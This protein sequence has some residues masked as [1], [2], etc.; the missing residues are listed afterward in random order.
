MDTVSVLDKTKFLR[1]RKNIVFY[2]Y[3]T[4]LLVDYKG[5]TI[6]VLNPLDSKIIKEINGRKNIENIYQCLKKTEKIDQKIYEQS[7]YKMLETGI[8]LLRDTCK[9]EKAI[10]Y[11]EVGKFY[12][13]SILIEL[14]NKCNFSCSFCYKNA[15]NK[16]VFI[17]DKN[18]EYVYDIIKEKVPS[19][20]LTGGEPTLHPHIEKYIMKFADVAK[21]NINTN[22]SRLFELNPEIV[23]LLNHVQISLYGTNNDEYMKITK[24]EK[25]FD[26]VSKSVKLLKTL[27]VPH[28]IAVTLCQDTITKVEEFIKASIRIGAE[29][30]KIGLADEFGREQNKIRKKEY[31]KQID[32]L[33]EILKKLKFLYR[34]EIKI[35]WAG[36]DYNLPEVD[37]ETYGEFLKCGSGTEYFTISQNGRVRVCECLNEDLFDM[38]DIIAL[39]EFIKG[40]FQKEK[41]R[42]SVEE[43]MRYNRKLPCEALKA[44]ANMHL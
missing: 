43:Y 42:C 33:P 7:I 37:I 6:L 39:N 24:I 4:K 25:G 32:E 44:Y 8:I 31:E 41:L 34:N 18:I 15:L 9:N 19:I 12:P 13:K 2:N 20:L 3:G 35:E 38:G 27:M 23:L 40:N 14:T 28:T 1:I 5:N 21:V 29:N 17:S 16:G 30:M 26:K 36:V 11:G 22:G 10:I